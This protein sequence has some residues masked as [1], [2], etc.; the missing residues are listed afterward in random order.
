LIQL[1]NFLIDI[2][3]AA[4]VNDLSG[5]KKLRG[6]KDYYRYRI[7][8]YRIGFKVVDNEVLILKIAHRKEIYR[9]FP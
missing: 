8:E 5:I 3:A 2:N 9:N 6:E 1:K 4:T 7:G